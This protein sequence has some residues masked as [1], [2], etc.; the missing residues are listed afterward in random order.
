VLYAAMIL[1][2]Y[3]APIVL[4]FASDLSDWIILVLFTSPLA[5]PLIRTL[6]TRT[7][8]PSLNKT[9]AGTGQLLAV[10]SVVLS[11]GLLL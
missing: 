9:L 1:L 2:A 5:R 4:V 3:V 6:F 11:A 8:G 7:D 10:Y